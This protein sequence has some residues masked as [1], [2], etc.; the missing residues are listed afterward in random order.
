MDA[1]EKFILGDAY[2]SAIDLFTAQTEEVREQLIAL[3]V[4]PAKVEVTGNIKFDALNLEAGKWLPPAGLKP[5]L[6]A[7][8]TSG[9]PVIVAGCVTN[10]SEQDF[11][12]DAFQLVLKQFPEALLVLTPRHPENNERMAQLSEMLDKRKLGFSF[13]SKYEEGE[14]SGTSV[15]VLDT[16]GELKYMYAAADVCFVGLNHNVLEPLAANKP[17][18]VTH[19]W[20]KSYPSYPVYEATKQSGLVVEV[21]TP[22]ELAYML[23]KQLNSPQTVSEKVA[24]TR[25]QLIQGAS[26]HNIKLVNQKMEFLIK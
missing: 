15:L 13:R 14:L 8:K 10:I 3:G 16:M 1:I 12:L 23:I 5:L 18:I 7:I 4:E 20:E 9:R 6:K 25:L 24:K 2:L 19:G 26:E 22:D 21:V 17:V 11:V